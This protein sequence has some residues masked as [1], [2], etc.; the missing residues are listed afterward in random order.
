MLD[1]NKIV[2]EPMKVKPLKHGQVAIYKLCDADTVDR[3]RVD[4]VTGQPRSAQPRYSLY[5]KGVNILDPVKGK[6][7]LLVNYDGVK[8]ETNPDGSQK[9]VP[10]CKRVHFERNG[11]F[12]VD[13]THE[14]TYIFMER[15]PRNRDNPYRDRTK[16]PIFYRVNNA[17]VVSGENEKFIIMADTMN[18]IMKADLTELQTIYQNLDPT[19]KRE[20][21]PN[22][23]DVL[24]RDLFKMVQKDP[25]LVMRCSSN[26]DV[27]MK[28]QMMDAEY[29]GIITFLEG[30]E[31][32]KSERTWVYTDGTSI[33]HVP[34]DTNKIEGLIS[35]FEEKEEKGVKEYQKI[36]KQLKT[37]SNP[38]KVEEEPEPA[39]VEQ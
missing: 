23:F 34:I 2:S 18:H 21:N 11:T 35:W 38:Q 3:S 36:I 19:S 5:G 32:A 12:S 24:K 1:F 20:V 4:E 27:K 22:N 39:E 37:I 9:Q 31:N 10:N 15:H 29:F 16:K 25:I 6:R 14:G 26:K 13:A 30:A 7:Y 33:C 28:I 8:F 17:K